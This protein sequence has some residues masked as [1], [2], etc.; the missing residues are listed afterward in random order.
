[1]PEDLRRFE[2]M[3]WSDEHADLRVPAS[4]AAGITIEAVPG[5]TWAYANNGFALLG[6]ILM[7]TE[8]L[9]TVDAVLRKRIFAPLGMTNTDALDHPHADLS[10]GYHRAPDDDMRELYARIGRVLPDEETVDGHN[11]R[12]KYQ[13]ERAEDI[14]AAGAVQSTIPDMAKYTSALLRRGG[15]IVRPETFHA[16]LAPQWQPDARMPAIGLTFFLKARFGRQTF[17][18]GGGVTGG[19]N[20]MLTVVTEDDL[21]LLLHV[22]LTFD[23]LEEVEGRL[24]QAALDAPPRSLPE[25]PTDPALLAAAPGVYEAPAPGPLTNFRVVTTF[26][27]MQITDEA[28]ALVFRTR[29]GRWKQGARMLPCDPGDPTFFLLDSGDVEPQHVALLRDGD[30]HV[31]GIRV[32]ALAARDMVRNDAIA[33]WA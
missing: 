30:G 33:R 17:G 1:M 28:G 7:R 23:K 10:T 12:G 25:L 20:T 15:G 32:A 14:R 24:L 18:H 8:D 31:T 26:G 3:L 4:Y 19:W 27:R 11:I 13:Y 5:T 21:A 9:D 16:M 22:N 29:R 2:E 6:E